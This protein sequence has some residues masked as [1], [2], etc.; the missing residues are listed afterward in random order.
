MR[1]TYN[2]SLTFLVIAFSTMI[3]IISIRLTLALASLAASAS[4]AIALISCAGTLTSFTWSALGYQDDGDD[5]TNLN[6]LHLYPPLHSC[7]I[8]R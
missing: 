8:K 6:P 4:A 1:F 2:P 3:V 5:N 7:L